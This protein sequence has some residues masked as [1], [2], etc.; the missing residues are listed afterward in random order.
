MRKVITNLRQG[1]PDKSYK[2]IAIMVLP[3][4]GNSLTGAHVQCNLCYSTCLRHLISSRLVTNRIS[5]SKKKHF[6]LCV[7]N[8]L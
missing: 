7:L 5:L 3:L 4:D 6:P 2:K 1:N 8:M